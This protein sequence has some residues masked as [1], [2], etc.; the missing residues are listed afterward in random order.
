MRPLNPSQEYDET[1]V[2]R[3]LAIINRSAEELDTMCVELEDQNAKLQA[4]LTAL[5]EFVHSLAEFEAPNMKGY[6]YKLSDGI[7]FDITD[8]DGETITTG[9]N[10]L[11]ALTKLWQSQE[12]KDDGE[13]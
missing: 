8:Y 9:E 10:A 3:N 2:P 11:E 6:W 5:R 7:H 12:Q 1:L 13:N 4:E